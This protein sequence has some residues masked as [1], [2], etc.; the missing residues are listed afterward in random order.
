MKHFSIKRYEANDYEQW[1][2]FVSQAKNATFLFHRDFMEYHQDRFEDF[3]LMAFENEKLIAILPAN[4]VQNTVYSHQGLTYGGLV[5]DDKLKLT[6]I[7]EI[8]KSVLSFL[9]SNNIEKVLIKLIPSIYHETPTEEINYALF[10]AEAKLIRRD[11]MSVIDLSKPYFISKTRKECIRRGIKNQLIIKEDLD[12]KAFWEEVLIPNLETKHQVKPV[13]TLE[14]ITKLQQKFPNNIKHF[15]VYYK[16]KIVAGTTVF[17]SKQVAHP[18][19]VSGNTEKNELGSLD[20]LYHHLI[21]NV[22][23]DIRFFDFGISNENEGKKLNKGLV[24]WKE[25]FGASTLAHDFYE[26]ETANFDKLNNVTL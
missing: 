21:T 16:N 1:N 8:F 3:S 13:H 11:S 19:Y 15:N 24:F 17:V 25:S 4:K 10:L 23:K 18:Q 26:V 12:F 22:F 20:F 9:H 14:E 5:Y 7:I 2:A 6:S